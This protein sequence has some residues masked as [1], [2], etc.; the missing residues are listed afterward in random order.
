MFRK[1][2]LKPSFVTVYL[3]KIY[4]YFLPFVLVKASTAA[5]ED[6]VTF[7]DKEEM[8]TASFLPCFCIVLIYFLKADTEPPE[9]F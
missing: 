1:T 6:E 4:P 8:E 3:Y 5:L 9:N 2:C 7:A